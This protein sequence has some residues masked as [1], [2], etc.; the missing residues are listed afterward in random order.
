MNTLRPWVDRLLRHS[1][2]LLLAVMVLNVVWQVV[3]RFV[4]HSPSPYTEEFARFA[5]IWLGLLGAA[6][7]VG[8]HTHLALDLLPGALH[9]RARLRLNRVITVLVLLFALAVLVG[10]G[11]RLVWITWMLGQ[12]SAALEIRLA[13]VYLAVPAAGLVMTF[14]C[15]CELLTAAV[16]ADEQRKEP[17]P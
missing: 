12:T 13:W 7:G 15:V 17:V 14:Y 3:T 9:G 11:S 5:M 2:A 10:G 4:L 16:R 6:H 8:R 1:I